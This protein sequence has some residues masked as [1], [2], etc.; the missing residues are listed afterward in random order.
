M[1]ESAPGYAVCE[2]LV[3]ERHRDIWLAS[4]FVPASARAH[5]LALYAFDAEIARVPDIVSQ[6]TLGEIRLQW[7]HEVL[8]GERRGEGQ[9]HPV[10]SALLDTMTRFHLPAAALVGLVEARRF[11]LYADPMPSMNDLEGYCGETSASLFRLASLIAASGADP[12]GADA[13]GHAGVAWGLTEILR[14]LPQ[15][16]RRGQCYLPRDV[17]AR[18]GALVE[19]AASGL[20]SPALLLALKDLRARARQHLEMARVEL[21]KMAPEIRA[22]FLPLSLVGP[23]L[24]R[25]E[26]ADWQPFAPAP[27]LPQW[28]QQFILWRAARAL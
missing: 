23:R 11:D 13:A 17:L 7:W 1:S 18:H 6:P 24:A 26:R 5:V 21:A 16:V 28:R 4:L 19:A 9:A 15:H 12:G 20:T 3:R 27:D 22:V 10:A 2:A 14:A 8:V 25:M